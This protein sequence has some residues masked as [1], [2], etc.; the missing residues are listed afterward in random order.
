MYNATLKFLEEQQESG[1]AFVIRPKKPSEVGRMEKDVQKLEALY[2][3]G[4]RDAEECFEE[5]INYLE[6]GTVQE[7]FE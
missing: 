4:Y 5:M 1:G 6:S 3:E 7:E 2:R